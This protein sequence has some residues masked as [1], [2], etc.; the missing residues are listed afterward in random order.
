MLLDLLFI[1][2]NPNPEIFTIPGIDREVRWYGLC[3]ALAFACSIFMTNYVYKKEGKNV[4]E[5]DTLTWYAILGVII[6]ARLGHCLFYSPGYYLSNPLEIFKIW[7]GGLASHGGALGLLIGIILYCRKYK[8]SLLWL[9]DRIMLSVAICAAFIRFGNLMNSEMIGKYTDLPFAF[10]FE[11]IDL[12]PR[13]PAQL[14]EGLF[15]VFLFILF[16]ILYQKKKFFD[17]PG[18]TFGLF[19]TLMF[20]QRF[21]NEML[22]E[23]QELWEASLP[24]NMGQILSLPFIIFGLLMMY[25]ANKRKAQTIA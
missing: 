19:L 17:R 7:E 9:L 20:I 8:T 14:Y 12:K 11:A 13:H 18:F 6:G 3:W 23:V 5:V 2:W 10:I 16:F 21:F 1:H 22:K 4:K 15:S 25:Y 24:I